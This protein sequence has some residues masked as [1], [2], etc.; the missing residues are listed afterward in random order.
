[1]PFVIG[2][3]IALVFRH[4]IDLIEK[5]THIKRS[6]VSIFVL[7]VFYGIIG[8]IISMIGFKVFTFLENFVGSTPQLYEN[9]IKPALNHIIDD[10]VKHYPG[11]RNYLENFL[12][13]INDSIFS[14]INTVSTK[15]LGTIAGLAGQLPSLLINLIFTIVASFFFTIDY[16]RITRFIIRQFSGERKEM[17]LK[18]KDNGIGTLGRFIRAYA[19]IISITFMEL[20]IGFWILQIPTPF[21]FGALVAIIDILPILGTGAVLLPWAIISIILGNTKLGIGLLLLYI[22]IT[23]VRQAIEPKI[24]GQQIGL[25]PILTLL[26]MYVGVQLMGVLGLLLLPIIATI[27]KKLNDEGTIHLFK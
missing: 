24:V 3:I 17:L 26:L 14:Y 15:A 11:I 4:P 5:K 22:L 8:F 7:L 16:Y 13:N 25:H 2:I 27:L 23:V 9:S 19:A 1:M 18:L 20:S 10:L 21:V 6:F 12:V